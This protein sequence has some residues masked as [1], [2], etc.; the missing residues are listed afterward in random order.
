MNLI[1]FGFKGSGKTHFGKLVSQKLGRRFID[2]DRLIEE[3]LGQNIRSIYAAVGEKRFRRIEKKIIAR[4]TPGYAVIALG[5]GAIFASLSFLRKIGKLIYL[6][7]SLETV[8]KRV[9]SV[10]FSLQNT[11]KKRLPRYDAIQAHRIDIEGLSE[12]KIVE[13]I[14]G[15]L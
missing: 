9:T 3:E 12:E 6:R 13:E 5:G 15:A 2:T 1:L 8:Q 10:P 11:Y 14:I 4:L 7:I